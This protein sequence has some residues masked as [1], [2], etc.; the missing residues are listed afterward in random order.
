MQNCRF[1]LLWVGW[2]SVI[3]FFT[4]LFCSFSIAFMLWQQNSSSVAMSTNMPS[5]FQ[6]NTKSFQTLR[7]FQFRRYASGQFCKSQIFHCLH[8]TQFKSIESRQIDGKPIGCYCFE[9]VTS[10]RYTWMAILNNALSFSLK[11]TWNSEKIYKMMAIFCESFSK[12]LQHYL[13]CNRFR[14]R[15]KSR[16]RDVKWLKFTCIILK[17]LKGQINKWILCAFLG[18]KFLF[19]LKFACQQIARWT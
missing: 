11:K 14:S 9:C 7:A 18:T 15:G 19:N 10:P 3:V 6:L 17:W 12:P 5:H 1:A 8:R 4:F 13:C 2:L 16:C